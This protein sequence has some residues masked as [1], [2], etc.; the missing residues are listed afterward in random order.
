MRVHPDRRLESVAK[1]RVAV[2]AASA[3]N[4]AFTRATFLPA[5][6]LASMALTLAC[7]ALTA[8][9]AKAAAI[10]TAGVRERVVVGV[11]GRLTLVIRRTGTRLA[12]GLAIALRARCAL[13]AAGKRLAVTLH[14]RTAVAVVAAFVALTF[15][16][17]LAK[18][19]TVGHVLGCAAFVAGVGAHAAAVAKLTVA[20]TVIEWT[21]AAAVFARLMVAVAE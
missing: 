19:A 9:A 5:V 11:I 16:L 20:T 3:G 4:A 21:V 13:L 14:E 6:A 12:G 17:T 2:A 1:A 15:A 10:T 18:V 8:V 7:R